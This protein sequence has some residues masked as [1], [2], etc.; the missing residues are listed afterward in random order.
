[1]YPRSFAYYRAASLDEA[2][3]LLRELGPEAKLLAGGQSLVPLMKLRLSSPAALVDL[4]HLR[5]A[6]YVKEDDDGLLLGPLTRHADVEHS[7]AAGKIPILGDCAAG[8]ADVQVRNWGTVVGSIA[9]ADPTGDWAPVLLTLDSQV[10]CR[11]TGRQRRIALS[12]FIQDAFTTALEPGELVEQLEIKAPGPGSGGCYLAFKRCAPVYASASV[13]VQLT[14]QDG[15]C[16]K[17]RVALGAVA[18]TPVIANQA[19]A[20]LEGKAIDAA[21]VKRASEAAA[22][23][24]EPPSDGRGSAEYKRALIRKLFAEAAIVAARRARGEAVE[25]SHHYA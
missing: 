3:A 4:G 23:A 5:G 10:L 22:A 7:A 11:S 14:M 9:E 21:T 16:G 20:A 25:V 1:M 8:I 24:C 13:A 6:D 17:A 12:D 2:A 15:V 18:L 19:A